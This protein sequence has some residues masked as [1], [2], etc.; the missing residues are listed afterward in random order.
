M[1]VKRL[2]SKLGIIAICLVMG[3]VSSVVSGSA[4]EAGSEVSSVDSGYS[5]GTGRRDIDLETTGQL[6]LCKKGYKFEL[7]NVKVDKDFTMPQ[8]KLGKG[9]TFKFYLYNTYIKDVVGC[10]AMVGIYKPTAVVKKKGFGYDYIWT[11]EY[12]RSSVITGLSSK[13]RVAP[14]NGYATDRYTVSIKGSSKCTYRLVAFDNYVNYGAYGKPQEAIFW[15]YDI[16]KAYDLYRKYPVVAVSVYN[17]P[18]SVTLKRS[19]NKSSI[20]GKTIT[21]K[22]GK[23]LNVYESTPKGSYANAK[24]IIYTSSNKKVAS[25]SKDGTFKSSAKIKALKKGTATITVRLYNGKTSSVKIK[26]V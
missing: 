7:T 15:G 16:T 6:L 22:R 20:A 17:A 3:A 21:L 11:G 13:T 9:E 2:L 18:S 12:N 26:V 25:V 24:N 8:I 14:T 5:E 19:D 1:K 4:A 23:T 10:P